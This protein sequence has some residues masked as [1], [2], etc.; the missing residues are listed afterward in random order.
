MGVR[1]PGGAAAALIVAVALGG[2]APGFRRDESWRV[3]TTWTRIAPEEVPV[4]L[5]PGPVAV[6]GAQAR[7]IGTI[8]RSYHVVLS[9]PTTLPQEN[10]LDVDVEW[11]AT[12]ILSSLDRPARPYPLP[13]YTLERLNETLAAEFPGLEPHVGEIERHNRYGVYDHAYATDGTVTCVLAWQQITDRE[14]VLPE[15]IASIRLEWRVCGT[16]GDPASLLAPFDAL[17]LTIDPAMLEL[18]AT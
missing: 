11:M 2:C 13:L 4:F 17:R 18:P 16:G 1:L 15:T 14:R 6:V 9:N 8:Y 3:P 7:D 5:S 12:D 10:R